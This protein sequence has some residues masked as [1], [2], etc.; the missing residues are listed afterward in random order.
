MNH[1]RSILPDYDVFVAPGVEVPPGTITEA[2][3]GTGTNG[4]GKLRLFGLSPVVAAMRGLGEDSSVVT[5]PMAMPGTSKVGTGDVVW[6][7]LILGAVG[8]L[9]YQAGK[10]I[11]PSREKQTTWGWI[12][13]PV[14][15]FTG[16]VGLGVMGFVANQRKG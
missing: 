16:V 15:L 9:S 14:G 7:V 11:A 6:G 8:A 12:G 4:L 3:A 2:A 1:A 13:V 10:A 5:G